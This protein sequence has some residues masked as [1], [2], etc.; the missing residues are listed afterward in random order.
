[1]LGNQEICYEDSLD[2][3][4]GAAEKLANPVT[5]STGRDMIIRILGDCYEKKEQG[6]I[7]DFEKYKGLLKHL[8]KK[9]GLY[10]YLNTEFEDLELED[11]FLIESNKPKNNK[12]FIFHSAQSK[13][14]NHIIGGSNIILSAP[15]S[16]GKSA[17]LSNVLKSEKYNTVVL[18]VPTIALIDET[19]KKLT[20]ELGDTFEVIHHNCQSPRENVP[21]IYILTQE[22]LEKRDDIGVVDLFILDEFYKLSFQYK[23]KD[24]TLKYDER[25]ISL[26][27]TVFNMI[28][29]SKQ[30]LFIGPNVKNVNGLELISDDYTF[31]SSDFKTVAVNI[32]ESHLKS[33]DY[34]GKLSKTVEIIK[35]NPKQKTIIYCSSPAKANMI[36]NDISKCEILDDDL[37]NEKLYHWIKESYDSEWSYYKYLK[38][39]IIIHHG[40]LPRAM[41]HLSINLFSESDHNVLIC[42]S[43][44]IEGVNTQAKNVIIFDNSNGGSAIDK[45][46]FNN[47]KG[48]AGRMYKHFVGNVYCLESIPKDDNSED[49][50]IPF[51]L[52]PECTPLNL[53]ASI[54]EE[55]RTDISN[56]RWENYYYG[57]KV[58]L[59]IIKKNSSMDISNIEKTYDLLIGIFERDFPLYEKLHFKRL[60]QKEIIDTLIYLLINVRPRALSKCD[61]KLSEYNTTDV[62]NAVSTKIMSFLYSD[63]FTSYLKEQFSHNKN[64]PHDDLSYTAS[65]DSEMKLV[66]YFFNFTFPSFLSLIA[67]FIEYI[68]EENSIDLDFDFGYVISQLENLKLPSGFSAL[69]EMGVP[70]R[71]IEKIRLSKFN[72]DENSLDDVKTITKRCQE[73]DSPLL[74][75]VDRYF[76]SMARI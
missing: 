29:R 47:I 67:D 7:S 50:D 65:I 69:N 45:F 15:T 53:I 62:I 44:I 39:G 71:T 51:G 73:A 58:P 72:I 22:R 66:S 40:V 21:V 4:K 49:V 28:K 60:P 14:Y 35:R 61:V 6:L 70:H 13:I 23:K 1:M 16:M 5:S 41:Q 11:I 33:C 20:Y 3:I 56:E 17:L 10:P 75:E 46:T 34:E 19:R 31:V 43:T 24:H 59:H 64:N 37:G 42:T 30:W 57:S 63:T 76:I 8:V 36:A 52:Q 32:E 68:D 38:K 54:D 25:V 12:D 74:D 18:I 48:R 55:Y 9:S 27:V 26:N 2:Y